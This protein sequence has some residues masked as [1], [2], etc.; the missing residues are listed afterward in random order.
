MP[1]MRNLVRA[2]AC[3]FAVALAGTR[4]AGLTSPHEWLQF[5]LNAANNAVLPGTLATSW[6]V[7]TGGGFSSSPALVD[8]TV[9]IGNNAGELFALDAATGKTRWKFAAK[10]PL[11]SNPLVIDDSVIVG[12]GD[13]N[14]YVHSNDDAMSVGSGENAIISVDRRNGKERWRVTMDGSAMPTPALIGGKLVHHGGSGLLAALD[15]S[16]GK[17]LYTRD[18]SSIASMSAAVPLDDD[19]FVSA[20]QAQNAVWAFHANDGS[21]L[22]NSRFPRAASGVGDCPPAAD[23]T[24]VY[25]D[26]LMPPDGYKE[27]GVGQLATQHVYALDASTG[28]V[29]WDVATESGTAPRFNEASIPLLDKGTIFAGSSVAPW[30]HAFDAS[31]GK[32]AWRTAVHGPVK[33]GVVAKDGALYF[34]DLAGYL[35]ALDENSGRVLGCKHFKTVF[36][37]GSPIIAGRTLIIGSN[38]GDII[39][40]PLSDIRSA[41]DS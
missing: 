20:G 14:T 27:T 16:S 39:A 5:R 23:R 24:R 31:T 15:P 22:W 28:N 18:L 12:E 26:Y 34:G 41:K 10:A 6:V 1:R 2:G 30:M 35:W 25:C 38:T 13:Q 8:D 7:H 32:L 11:M 4:H 3:V 33:G 40:T 21:T 19:R 37:V 9:Y 29:L 36:N 17:I